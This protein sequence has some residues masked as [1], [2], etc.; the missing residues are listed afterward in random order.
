MNLSATTAAVRIAR[1][2]EIEDDIRRRLWAFNGD[3]NARAFD[4]LVEELARQQ[5]RSDRS[6]CYREDRRLPL[7][8]GGPR[9]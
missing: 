5:Y 2:A 9:S 8:S 4:D 7:N 3:G 6:P 1:L